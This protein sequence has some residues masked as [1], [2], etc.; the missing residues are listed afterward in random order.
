MA[1]E[2]SEILFA[3]AM[4]L[5]KTVVTSLARK[6]KA[7]PKGST[8]YDV[9]EQIHDNQI[10]KAIPK[11]IFATGP[12]AKK[13]SSESETVQA[14]IKKVTLTGK[15]DKDEKIL[16]D[17]VRGLSAA[18]AMFKE[19]P[20]GYPDKPNAV[21]MT[22]NSW[23]GP[24]E[25]FRITLYEFSDYNSTDIMLQFNGVTPL[26]GRGKTNMFFGISLKKKDTAQGADPTLIN[27]A[28]DT[29]F[30]DPK[31][32]GFN[33]I[34][35]SMEEVKKQTLID[36]VISGVQQNKISFKDI[37]R[38]GQKQ[39]KSITE[40][41]KW[42]ETEPGR[43][44]LYESK[45]IDST[46]FKKGSSESGNAK[47]INVKGW[48]GSYNIS[49]K[50]ELNDKRAMRKHVNT[51]LSN[52]NNALWQKYISVIQSNAEFLGQTLLSIILRT[53]LEKSMIGRKDLA[54][55]QFAF[56]LCTGVGQISKNNVTG[57]D[58]GKVYSLKTIL[59]G[60]NRIMNDNKLTESDYKVTINSVK[61][62][63]SEAAKLFLTLKIGSFSILDMEVRF[64]GDFTQQPQYQ[65][66]ISDEFSRELKKECKA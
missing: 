20:T 56:Y 39:F 19:I 47:Y 5:G 1:Y 6:I 3:A 27:K 25:K 55:T 36:I 63:E 29:A 13:G 46:K 26:K 54:G 10:M 51:Q 7:P 44:E 37:N 41:D 21:Y 12:K 65:A 64:K 60:L 48:P 58:S 30:Y 45:M 43:T 35:K 50:T 9:V 59:C 16:A 66:F 2:P 62:V 22:G 31:N 15:R 17:T 42:A 34:K 32:K 28:F 52:I 14:F 4:C 11:V 40:F 53:D 24:I 33:A 8:A 49:K 57:L 18:V 23:P 61:N 38:T